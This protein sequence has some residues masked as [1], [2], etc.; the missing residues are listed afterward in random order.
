MPPAWLPTAGPRFGLAA[1]LGLRVSNGI[2]SLCCTAAP[3]FNL[4]L[5]CGGPYGVWRGIGSS[6][7]MIAYDADEGLPRAGARGRDQGPCPRKHSLTT[8]AGPKLP[9]GSTLQVCWV[10]L[11][12]QESTRHNCTWPCGCCAHL[13]SSQDTQ[14]GVALCTKGT[15]PFTRGMVLQG[16]GISVS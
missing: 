11:A 6:S 2:G 7:E 8:H 16:F 10:S 4:D 1:G 9:L 12:L 15:T 5:R 13:N 3:A 14:N